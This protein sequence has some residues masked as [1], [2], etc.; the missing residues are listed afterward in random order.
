MIK[1]LTPSFVMNNVEVIG[2]DA[3]NYS[4]HAIFHI[5]SGEPVLPDAQA[6]L[7][8]SMR[9]VLRYMEIE[10]FIPEKLTWKINTGF[11]IHPPKK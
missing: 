10:G 7:R 5:Y 6:N 1:Q 4:L 2:L 9:K 3:N 11:I 8:A